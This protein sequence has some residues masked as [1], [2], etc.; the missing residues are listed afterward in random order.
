MNDE[1]VVDTTTDETV[2]PSSKEETRRSSRSVDKKEPKIR[3]H[4][5]AIME[6]RKEN[7]RLRKTMEEQSTAR[8]EELANKKLDDLRA[9]AEKTATENAQ[10]LIEQRLRENEEITRSRLV[11][12]ELKAHALKANV[13]D[14]DDLYLILANDLKS[15]EVDSDGQVTNAA[16]LIGNI[17]TKKPYL[18]GGTNTTSTERAPVQREAPKNEKPALKMS[19]QEYEKAK[20]RLGR[21]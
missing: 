20:A 6:L 5:D 4:N 12:A 14:W 9:A 21:M 15:I 3:D 8:A 18:F 17:K 7:E 19:R 16:E 2:E 11:K 13:L 10:K 1:D